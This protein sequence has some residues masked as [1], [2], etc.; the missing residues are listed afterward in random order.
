V[1]T[2]ETRDSHLFTVT[3]KGDCPLIDEEAVFHGH[4]KDHSGWSFLSSVV[5]YV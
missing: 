4:C 1:E 5:G 3:E 2:R